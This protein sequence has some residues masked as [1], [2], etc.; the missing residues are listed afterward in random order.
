M[1]IVK[2]VFANVVFAVQIFLAFLLFFESSVSV[3]FWL[4]SFGRLHPLL[5]H[6]P[7][8]LLLITALLIFTRKYFDSPT[9]SDLVSLLIHCTAL[10]ASLS[11]LMGFFLSY[12]GGYE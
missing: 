6:L 2:K 1:E 10:F 4:Q 7:I 8:G 3:P 5:L 11:A 9:F 12:E